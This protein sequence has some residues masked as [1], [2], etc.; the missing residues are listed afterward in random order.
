MPSAPTSRSTSPRSFLRRA[1]AVLLLFVAGFL[2]VTYLWLIATRGESSPLRCTHDLVDE[3]NDPITN[4]LDALGVDNQPG[5]PMHVV[6]VP[7]YLDGTDPLIRH[8]YWDLLPGAD[9]GVFPSFYEPWGYTPQ[10]SLAVGVP[11]ITS[12]Y[13]GF[14]RWCSDAELTAKDGVT[15]LARVGID[16]DEAVNGLDDTLDGRVRWIASEAA[17][18]P[19]FALTER[20]RGRLAY[21][22]KINIETSGARLP[23]GVP[24]E[25]EL[26]TGKSSE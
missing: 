26:D 6:H 17:F 4:Q 10:E 1:T 16:D 12:D 9:L 5:A 2:F 3:A 22:A 25:V 21:E 14:G 8:K 13:A 24:V 15:V 23:D 18:T 7:I 11:T 19:Y 20:D